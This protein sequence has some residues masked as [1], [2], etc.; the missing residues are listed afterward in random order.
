[1]ASVNK[2]IL[3]GNCGRDVDL[4]H[5]PSGQGVANV[6]IA[7]T[8]KRKDKASNQWIED[9]QWHR[10]VFFDQLAEIASKYL[11]KGDPVY[12]EGKI[13]Y[14]KFTDKDGVEKNTTDIVVISMQ[15]LGGRKEGGNA[16][17]QQQQAPAQQGGG[18]AAMDDDG[19]PF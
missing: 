3:M 18:F 19:I 14:R 13:N 17:N 5:L 15:L 2:V 10:L 7:T 8:S 6:S 4:H 9:T 11:K 1:M 16:Q 12:I